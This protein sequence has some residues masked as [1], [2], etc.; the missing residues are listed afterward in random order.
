MVRSGDLFSGSVPKP[1]V[2]GSNPLGDAIF[3]LSVAPGTHGLLGGLGR[4]DAVIGGREIF[5]VAWQQRAAPSAAL[6]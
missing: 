2:G 5:F 4:S 3:I 6:T 1:E